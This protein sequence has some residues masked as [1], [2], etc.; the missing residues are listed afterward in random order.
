MT[1]PNKNKKTLQIKNKQLPLQK[2]TVHTNKTS[3]T[4]LPK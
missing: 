1:T 4:V 2:R 3:K